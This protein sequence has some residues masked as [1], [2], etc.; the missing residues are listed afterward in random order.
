[1]AVSVVS[2]SVVL[3]EVVVVLLMQRTNPSAHVRSTSLLYP[4]Q[5]PPPLPLM[6]GPDVPAAHSSPH[7]NGSDCDRLVGT[8]VVVA[9]L[10]S[11]GLPKHSYVFEG[12]VRDTFS[13]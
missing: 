11:N 2:V 1:V 10:L 6:Q 13:E 12:H 5:T 3:D 9:L 8:E 7:E 4:I